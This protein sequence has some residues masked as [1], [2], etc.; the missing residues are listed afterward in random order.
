MCY[1]ISIYCL[2]FMSFLHEFV[3]KVRKTWIMWQ[4]FLCFKGKNNHYVSGIVWNSITKLLCFYNMQTYWLLWNF[5]EKLRIKEI[6]YLFRKHQ[7]TTPH[8]GSEVQFC[9]VFGYIGHCLRIFALSA[10]I[11]FFYQVTM[12]PHGCGGSDIVWS[13][14]LILT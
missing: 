13:F 11:F 8:P 9:L 1:N 4:Y 14:N 6:Q 7:K 5:E 3:V 2:Y 12:E 10:K